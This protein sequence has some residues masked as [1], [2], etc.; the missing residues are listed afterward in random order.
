MPLELTPLQPR[1]EFMEAS[2]AI[3][4]IESHGYFSNTIKTDNNHQS[5]TSKWLDV[6]KTVNDFNPAATAL[7]ALIQHLIRLKVVFTQ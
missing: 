2:T 1:T 4:M 3:T 5:G 7:G 6:L